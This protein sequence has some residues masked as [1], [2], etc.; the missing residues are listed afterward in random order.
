MQRDDGRLDPDLGVGLVMFSMGSLVKHDPQFTSTHSTNVAKLPQGP[1]T[2]LVEV[3][4]PDIIE[5]TEA[6]VQVV[7][8]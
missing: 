1:S 6:A 3:F 2:A 8:L 7:S 4:S 5:S